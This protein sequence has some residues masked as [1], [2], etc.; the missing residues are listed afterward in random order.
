MKKKNINSEIKRTDPWLAEN[1]FYLKASTD[2]LSKFIAHYEIFKKIKRVPGAI[3]ECGVFRG[4]SASRFMHLNKIFKINK[5]FYGFDAFGKFPET[6]SKLDKKFSKL[7]N[8]KIGYGLSIKELDYFYKKNN[9]KKYN[10][11][12]G[13]I[14][15]SL[16]PLIRRKIKISLLH[17]DLDTFAATKF[18]LE[19]LYSLVSKNGIVLLDDYMHIK[20][21][22]IAVNEFLS[23][24]K[25]IKIEKFDFPCRPSFIIK[26]NN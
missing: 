3:V 2:R 4:A 6:G 8:K 11:I 1:S 13:D 20:N 14:T 16:I 9:F 5:M 25:K 21:T 23:K 10:L 24:N 19:N 7:H 26:K 12:K 22:T 15:K 18:A 17:L